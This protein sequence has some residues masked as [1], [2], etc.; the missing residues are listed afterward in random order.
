VAATDFEPTVVGTHL[1]E[2]IKSSKK[3]ITEIKE[4]VLDEFSGL[5]IQSVYLVNNYCVVVSSDGVKSLQNL[6]GAQGPEREIANLM[7][8]VIHKGINRRS[9]F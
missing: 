8:V 7:R 2:A 6:L 5:N 4:V 1:A 9:T 3:T